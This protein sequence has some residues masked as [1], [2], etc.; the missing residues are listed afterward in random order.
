MMMHF[1]VLVLVF[2]CAATAQ[3]QSF[4][5]GGRIGHQDATQ[6]Y[7]NPPVQYERV[8]GLSGGFAATLAVT[9]WLA[10]Q[11]EGL[12]AR[13]G[14]RLDRV[15]E[16]RIDYLEAPILARLSS[17]IAVRGARPF[18]VG[19]VAPAVELRCSGYTTPMTLSYIAVGTEP[20]RFTEPTLFAP[21]QGPTTVPLDCDGQRQRHTDRGRVFGGGFSLD[22]G[23]HQFV[24]E[25]RRTR[26]EDISGYDCCQL[27]NDATTILIGASRRM[28]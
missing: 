25:L 1:R 23:R 22:R 12:Y 18:L 28:R 4:L 7:L 24:I 10:F 8:Q 13:K 5:L 11:A 2:A 6:R 19:G 27:R 16:M 26:G 21:T 17:P 14:A 3:A 20:P 15:Y 9:P